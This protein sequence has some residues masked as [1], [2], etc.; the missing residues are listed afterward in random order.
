MRLLRFDVDAPLR[1]RPHRARRS[2]S[3]DTAARPDTGAR[4]LDHRRRHAVAREVPRETIGIDRGR[5]DDDL[6][7]GPLRQQAAQVAEQEIDVEA[8]L[9]RLVDDDRV[10]G[11]EHRIALGLGEQDA[12]GHQ[13]DRRAG[14]QAVLEAD[15]EADDVAE[16]RAEFRSD[17]TRGRGGGETTRLGVTDQSLA[18][19]TA[20]ATERETDLRQLRGLPRSGLATDD[21]DLMRRDRGRD[22]LATRRDRQFF[23]EGDVADQH[24]RL[25]ATLEEIPRTCERKR[26]RRSL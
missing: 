8:A 24:R 6:E 7:V 20:P 3:A 11:R 12:V 2:R 14:R 21:D 4:Y 15:L 18:A 26:G 23:R 16:L 22:V 19:G 5:R 9:V 17:A 10:V 13:L 1:V 25:D